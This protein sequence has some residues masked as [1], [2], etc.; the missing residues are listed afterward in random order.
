MGLK[1]T[2]ESHPVVWGLSL[3]VVG[4]V[5]GFETRAY[6]LPAASSEHR[7]LTCTVEGLDVLENAHQ[8]RVRGLQ[9]ELVQLESKASDPLV[10]S[11]DQ[12]KYRESADRIRKDIGVENAARQLAIEHLNARCRQS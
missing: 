11:S 2:F 10:V 9:D 4:F 1:E 12:N 8:M 6:V 7:L 5:A 3:L